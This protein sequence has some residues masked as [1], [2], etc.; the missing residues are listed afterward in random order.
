MRQLTCDGRR[1]L[2]RTAEQVIWQFQAWQ[3]SGDGSTA[4]DP[5][6]DSTV[7]SVTRQIESGGAGERIK[8]I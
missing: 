3:V 8:L 6:A 5:R 2:D 4:D 7:R 1:Q